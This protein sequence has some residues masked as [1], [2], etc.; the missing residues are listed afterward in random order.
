MSLLSACVWRSSSN[1]PLNCVET[2]VCQEAGSRPI[3]TWPPKKIVSK[4][5]AY[6]PEA[7]GSNLRQHGKGVHAIPTMATPAPPCSTEQVREGVLESMMVMHEDA[8]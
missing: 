6:R 5:G 8:V 4:M 7:P 1:I 2:V 3:R